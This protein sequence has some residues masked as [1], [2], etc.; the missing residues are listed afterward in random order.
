M[1]CLDKPSQCAYTHPPTTPQATDI[2]TDRQTDRQTDIN[3][4]VNKSQSFDLYIKNYV[5]KEIVC[6]AEMIWFST[7]HM[8]TE[9]YSGTRIAGH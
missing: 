3:H 7:C 9:L 1:V 2:L 6:L 8:H 4:A 5:R